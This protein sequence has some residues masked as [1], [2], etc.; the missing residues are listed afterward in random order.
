MLKKFTL[1]A[2]TA[3]A[4]SALAQQTT[5]TTT[6]T[7][8]S[9]GQVVSQS[10]T[11]SSWGWE[12][13]SW[14]QRYDTYAIANTDINSISSLDEW[15]ILYRQ[16][17]MIPQGKAYALND[18]MSRIPSDYETVLM[19]ALVNNFKQASMVRDEVAMARFGTNSTYAWL[20]YPPLTW[21]DTPG[22]NSWSTLTFNNNG[23]TAMTSGNTYMDNNGDWNIAM[24]DDSSRAMRMVMRHRGGWR[25]IDYDRAVEILNSGLNGNQR[26]II[27]EL[28]HPTANDPLSYS[29]EEA[30]DA[31]VCLI[32]NNAAM[33]DHL[34]RYAWYNHF[35]PNYY[36]RDQWAW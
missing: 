12:D 17:R 4:V 35:D 14:R 9:Q 16:E 29:N 7:T 23:S 19:H 21:S 27:N 25:D 36:S 8:N 24:R 32:N 34:D 22:Q 26:G 2:F 1:A 11:T 28:F 10:T 5:T 15:R 20:S 6:T 18:F 33:V 31:I 30:L 13:S 3:V